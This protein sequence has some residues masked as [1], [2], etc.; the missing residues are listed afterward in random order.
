M[1]FSGRAAGHAR[2]PLIQAYRP[3]R[4]TKSANTARCICAFVLVCFSITTPPSYAGE[5]KK[6]YASPRLVPGADFSFIARE[7]AHSRRWAQAGEVLIKLRRQLKKAASGPG[8]P[9]AGFSGA[10]V[11]YALAKCP[12]PAL[13]G[14]VKGFC[15][16]FRAKRD[17]L[18]HQKDAACNGKSLVYGGGAS[19]AGDRAFSAS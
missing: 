11:L 9:Q 5:S 14:R 3:R 13:L 6:A 8:K 19:D 10:F 1:C 17:G 18:Q 12:P 7:G 4:H 2:W 15:Y 16:Q